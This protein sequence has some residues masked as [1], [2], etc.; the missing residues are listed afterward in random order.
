MLSVSAAA[1]AEVKGDGPEA[2]SK[3][4]PNIIEPDPAMP[5]ACKNDLLLHFLWSKS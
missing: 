3:L 1:I 2:L 5:K 4:E